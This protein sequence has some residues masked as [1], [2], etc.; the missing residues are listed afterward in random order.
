LTA[1]GDHTR[2]GDPIAAS[3]T[4]SKTIKA[5]R[6]ISILTSSIDTRGKEGCRE[7][8]GTKKTNLSIYTGDLV[9]ARE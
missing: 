8:L 9:F 3:T 7:N 5:E 6:A 4:A 2:T 1:Y